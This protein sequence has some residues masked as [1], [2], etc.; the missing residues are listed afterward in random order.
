MQFR[1]LESASYFHQ[2]GEMSYR[3][4]NVQLTLVRAYHSI[5]AAVIQLQ[6]KGIRKAVPINIL[7]LLPGPER[8]DKS[9]TESFFLHIFPDRELVGKNRPHR[10][11]AVE[12]EPIDLLIQ[13][14][15]MFEIR[16]AVKHLVIFQPRDYLRPQ[17]MSLRQGP[18]HKVEQIAKPLSHIK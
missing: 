4:G 14:F 8:L 15:R 17:Q 13:I 11:V 6:H 12:L 5:P 2:L 3:R 9:V 18:Q 16:P 10:G 1:G 7:R